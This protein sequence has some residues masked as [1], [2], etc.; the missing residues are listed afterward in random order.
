MMED[1][2]GA[3]EQEVSDLQR[4]H[5]AELGYKDEE[6][7][8][9]RARLQQAEEKVTELHVL[10]DKAREECRARESE[11]SHLKKNL[12]RISRK[13]ERLNLQMLHLKGQVESDARRH[14]TELASALAKQRDDLE[15]TFVSERRAVSRHLKKKEEEFLNL[16]GE[17]SHEKA[18]SKILAERLQQTAEELHRVL[19]ENAWLRKSSQNDCDV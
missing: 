7:M 4:K 6:K 8:V 13:A 11:N 2:K 18:S 19:D 5:A 1:L 15:R 14:D 17:L 3:H 12:Q 10:L 16:D 9:L